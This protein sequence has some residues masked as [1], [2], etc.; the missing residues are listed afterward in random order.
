[1][2]SASA[3][4]ATL[5]LHALEVLH[6]YGASFS[7]ACRYSF[8][9]GRR[10]GGMSK[11]AKVRR[12]ATWEAIQQFASPIPS[13]PSDSG[14]QSEIVEQPCGKMTGYCCPLGLAAPSGREA[15]KVSHPAACSLLPPFLAPSMAHCVHHFQ[16]SLPLLLPEKP[17]RARASAPLRGGR[18]QARHKYYS[19][20]GK[21]SRA[22]ASQGTAD[23][24]P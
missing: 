22:A 4:L 16:H 8:R 9:G 1:M 21:E 10:G 12:Q 15:L 6:C 20:V 11:R 18:R 17:S 7:S 5:I 19:S 14:G 24:A 2:D 3:P 23:G 13:V